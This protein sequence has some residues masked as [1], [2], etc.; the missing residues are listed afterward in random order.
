[1]AKAE[2][3]CLTEC[4]PIK[5]GSKIFSLLHSARADELMSAILSDL[6]QHTLLVMCSK[7]CSSWNTL[8]KQDVVWQRYCDRLWEGKIYIPLR[9]SILYDAG[10]MRES[11]IQSLLDSTRTAIT[12]DE[13][14]HLSFNFRFKRSAGSYWTDRDPFWIDNK[15]LCISFSRDGSVNGFP[16]DIL[17]IKWHFVDEAGYRCESKGSFMRASINGRCVPTYKISRHTNWGFIIQVTI[18]VL[19][20]QQRSGFFFVASFNRFDTSFRHSC[21]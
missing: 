8:I 5:R 19:R 2:S 3:Q 16:W 10:R 1:M 18:A 20:R 12:T 21:A 13:L 9:F 4:F 11:F 6:G 7:V 17:Q 14:D 15:P